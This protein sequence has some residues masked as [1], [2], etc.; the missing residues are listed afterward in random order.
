MGKTARK[1]VIVLM[2]L[3]IL[4]IWGNS[5]LPADISSEESEWVRSLMEPILSVLQSGRIQASLTR[6]ADGVTEPRLQALLYKGIAWLDEHILSQ[7][8]SYLVRK[9]AHFT[10]Y[11]ILG[12]LMGLLLSKPNGRARFWWP[13]IM[14]L[15]VASID[16]TFQLFSEG[17]GAAFR[18]VMIDLSGATLGVILAALVLFILRKR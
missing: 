15:A 16:E 8:A 6:I 10:E 18:D 13:E 14:C 12:V 17:R 1:I 11:M 7:T 9:A 5:M 4:F 3:M 2:G